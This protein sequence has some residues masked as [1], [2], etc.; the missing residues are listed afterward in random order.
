M[1]IEES[2]IGRE[3]RLEQRIVALSEKRKPM[4]APKLLAVLNFLWLYLIVALA[5][6]VVYV[7]L[8][9]AVLLLFPL[10]ALIGLAGVARTA[11]VAI[12]K[13]LGIDP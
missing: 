5:T 6:A 12:S 2:A 7:L 10:V 9:V 4:L 1:S 11:W 13:A 8:F 3:K